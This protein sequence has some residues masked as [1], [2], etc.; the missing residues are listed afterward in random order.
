MF[1]TWFIISVLCGFSIGSI[2]VAK[3]YDYPVKFWYVNLKIFIRELL[4]RK[5][6]QVV[7]CAV[8]LSFWAALLSD[9]T[10]YFVSGH[11]YFFWPFTGFVAAALTYFVFEFLTV[12]EKNNK[13]GNIL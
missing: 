7:N 8:C 10:L 3:R 4:G 2:I 6:S 1:L 9:V 13:K 12:I 11:N 5:P